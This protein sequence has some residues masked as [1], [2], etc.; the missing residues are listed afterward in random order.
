MNPFI[1]FYQ[2]PLSVLAALGYSL[3][4][5]TLLIWTIGLTYRNTI[6]LHV[7]WT[8]Q[9][10]QQWQ[11]VPP[12]NFILRLSAIPAV[13]AIDAWAVAALIYILA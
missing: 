10:P 2:D 12:L 13:L 9:R 1:A 8:K 5:L 3:L 6:T 11:Y 4:L 7:R